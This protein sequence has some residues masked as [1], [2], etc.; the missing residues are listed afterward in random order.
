MCLLNEKSQNLYTGPK[1]SRHLERCQCRCIF[2]VTA[3]LPY[4]CSKRLQNCRNRASAL[5]KSV[6]FISVVVIVWHA[7]TKLLQHARSSDDRISCNA[8]SEYAMVQFFHSSDVNVENED[9][10][11]RGSLPRLVGGTTALILS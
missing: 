6:L 3:F 8:S 2:G 10:I 9:V 1:S 5:A 11:F 7:K 4:S